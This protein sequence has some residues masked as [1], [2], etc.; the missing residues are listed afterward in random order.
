MLSRANGKRLQMLPFCWQNDDEGVSEHQRL[1]DRRGN[2]KVFAIEIDSE[3]HEVKMV[4]IT[5]GREKRESE[6]VY[7]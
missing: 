4:M 7:D 3:I 1:L 5:V 2:S 6:N